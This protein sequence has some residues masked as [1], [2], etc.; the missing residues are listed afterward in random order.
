MNSERKK[1]PKNSSEDLL[2]NDS[3]F[4]D[5]VVVP[6]GDSI[7]LHVFAPRDIP[8]VVEEYIEQCLQAGILQVRIVHGRGTGVQRNIVR[9]LLE[10]HPMVISFR[11]AGPEAG[12]WGATLVWLRPPD[13]NVGSD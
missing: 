10:K 1:P 9:S 7:D 13:P 11:D 12:G 5:P 6:L 8:S 4:G 2:P 3:P